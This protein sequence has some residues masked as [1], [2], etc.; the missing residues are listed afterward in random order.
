M[1]LKSFLAKTGLVELDPSEIAAS[2]LTPPI[3]SQEPGPPV[4][5]ATLEK[6]AVAPPDVAPVV[7]GEITENTSL[8]SIYAVFG[9]APSAFPAERLLKVLDGLKGMDASSQ[10]TAIQAMAAASDSW[11]VADALG[12]AANKIAA[13]KAHVVKLNESVGAVRQ[14]AL[15]EQTRLMQEHGELKAAIA[16]QIA[17]LQ[18]A[19]ALAEQEHA[20]AVAATEARTAAAAAAGERETA[21]IQAEIEKLATLSRQLN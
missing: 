16:E 13:L 10:R 14:Q 4:V 8:D 15:S 2:A 18:Q 5:L 1:S 11:T 19:A 17:Q 20:S 7:T 21:R 9:V 6:A 12:D 3:R